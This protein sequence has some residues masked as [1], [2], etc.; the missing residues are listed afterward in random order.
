MTNNENIIINRLPAKTWYWLDVNETK[1]PW[2]RSNTVE[3]ESQTVTA[4]KAE[5]HEPVRIHVNTVDE[6]SNKNIR[7]EAMTGGEL[8][9]FMNYGT[10][11]NLAVHT[12]IIAHENSVVRLVQTQHTEENAVLY[13]EI[14]GECAKGARVELIQVFLGKGD[15]YSDSR[16]ELSGEKS[17]LKADIGYIGQHEQK[18]DINVV[19]NHTGRETESEINAGGALK[20]ASKKVFRGTIDFKRG[21]VNAVGNEQETVLMLGD[22]VQ[23]KTI[24]LIL[25]AEENVVGNHGATIGELDDDTLFY[26]ESRGIDREHAENIMARASIDRLS[27]MTEDEETQNIIS[28]GLKEVLGYDE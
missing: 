22:D 9:V 17:S 25:C 16:F 19:A 1:L 5:K 28:D 11:Y 8:T 18:I 21:A 24:P 20:D 7:L 13:N 4:A 26:F 23:N 27:R 3:L 14:N 15:V 12:E 10:R 2:D 6:Y